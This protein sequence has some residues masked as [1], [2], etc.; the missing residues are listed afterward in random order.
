MAD[1]QIPFYLLQMVLERPQ[2]NLEDDG[3]TVYQSQVTVNNKTQL[4][5]VF[6]NDS[7]TPMIVVTVYLTSKIDKY[8]RPS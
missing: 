7:V 3:L 1:R 5:R 6:V 2:Q 8:W 4:L